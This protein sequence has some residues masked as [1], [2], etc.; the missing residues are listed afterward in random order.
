[1]H[2]TA[3]FSRDRRYRYRLGRRWGDG[4]AVCFVLLNPSTAEATREDPTVRRCI[5]F[6]QSLGYAALEV[7][8]LY[9]YVAADPAELR[10]AGYPVGPENDLHIET[11]VGECARVILAWGVHATRLER[12]G[13]VLGLLQDIGVDPYCLRL[14]ASGHPE[15]PLRLPLGC[16]L[17]RFEV[18]VE[19]VGKRDTPAPDTL[20][21]VTTLRS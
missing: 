6:A 1:V 8:N 4:A 9:A 3:L 16:E 11:A 5:G 21:K 2:R 12:P 10:R 15:H 14:T 18:E 13:E 20:S 19:K 7:V 17:L